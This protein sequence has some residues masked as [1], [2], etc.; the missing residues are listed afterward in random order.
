MLVFLS[1][2]REIR[3]T[4]DGLRGRLASDVEI[5]PLYA[6]LSTDEQHRVF[7]R[8]SGPYRSRVVLATNVAE[9]S[10]TVP[11][12]RYVVDPGTARISRYSARLKVQRLPIEP[13]SQ[14]S[15]DQRKGR[16]GRTSDGIC[17]RLYSEEDFEARPRFTDPEILRTSLASVLLQMAV[18]GLGAVEDFPFLDPPDRRQVRDAV[19]LLQ[20]LGAFDPQGDLTR[21]GPP[22]GGAAGRPAD[23]PDGPR[24][25]RAGLRRR[26]HRHRRRAVDPGPARAPG[27]APRGGRRA[28]RALRRS[29]LGLPLPAEPLDLRRASASAS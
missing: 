15:A 22:A 8:P 3:D 18:A 1:G 16:C 9:T 6:R 19:T 12:I 24:G 2:E 5:L 21:L 10:L 11:G 27:R 17:I 14:A 13:I 7:R 28:P 26:G 23:G 29:G 20:E 4:A 25:R